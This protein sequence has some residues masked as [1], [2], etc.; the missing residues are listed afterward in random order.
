MRLIVLLLQDR[1]RGQKILGNKDSN[2]YHESND[3]LQAILIKLTLKQLKMIQ[4]PSNSIK[5]RY[6]IIK[7]L[8]ELQ[9]LYDYFADSSVIHP[10]LYYVANEIMLIEFLAGKLSKLNDKLSSDGE[11]NTI[12]I[13]DAITSAPDRKMFI[14]RPVE[15]YYHLNVVSHEKYLFQRFK[16]VFDCCA[17]D[18]EKFKSMYALIADKQKTELTNLVFQLGFTITSTSKQSDKIQNMNVKTDKHMYFYLSYL[19][20]AKCCDNSSCSARC[21]R[22]KACK[23]KHVWYCSKKCQKQQWKSHGKF[24]HRYLKHK[25]KSRKR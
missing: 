21:K 12:N 19:R 8:T 1:I 6:K 22:L 13:V 24:C 2:I 11:L 18:G 4:Y 3:F 17:V 14:S 23:C 5:T 16:I 9:P 20:S 25:R 10:S 7:L 15:K